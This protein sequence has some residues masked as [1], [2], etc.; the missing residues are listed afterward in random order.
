M[1]IV[2]TVLTAAQFER[3][4]A[5]Y[6]SKAKRGYVCRI[7]LYKVFN[8]IIHVLRTGCQWREL[9]IDIDPKTGEPE[10]TWYGVYHHYRKW[11]QDGSFTRLWE[12]SVITLNEAGE[13]D[14]TILNLDGTHTIAKNGGEAVGYNGQKKTTPATSFP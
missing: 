10:I 14:V 11:S 5:P 6:L 2:T 1:K 13:L 9:K 7:G 8:Y 4:I 12:S 3:H